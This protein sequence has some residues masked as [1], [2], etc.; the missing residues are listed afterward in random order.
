MR[1]QSNRYHTR[2]AKIPYILTTSLEGEKENEQL[3]QPNCPCLWANVLA[4]NWIETGE[5]FPIVN[6][7]I[8]IGGV[9]SECPMLWYV[10][11]HKVKD[12]RS[13]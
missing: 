10:K 1:S 6:C 4:F 11:S 3:R 12:N 13:S 5:C 2:E 9:T 8:H 7:D